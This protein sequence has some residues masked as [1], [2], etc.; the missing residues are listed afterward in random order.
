MFG[1]HVWVL[2]VE[3]EAIIFDD[4]GSFLAAIGLGQQ[5][6]NPVTRNTPVVLLSDIFAY[7]ELGNEPQLVAVSRIPSGIN[8]YCVLPFCNRELQR[9]FF[10][11]RSEENILKIWEN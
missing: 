7:F 1:H 6:I 4:Q 11:H 5:E 10:R 9:T 8:S 2:G 3:F